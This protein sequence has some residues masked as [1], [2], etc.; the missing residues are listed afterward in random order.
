MTG[1]RA[2]HALIGT[3]KATKSTGRGVHDLDELVSILV[4]Q[5]LSG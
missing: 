4:I 3:A 2:D 1:P 5:A